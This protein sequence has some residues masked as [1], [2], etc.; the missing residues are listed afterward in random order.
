MH[1]MTCINIR[2]RIASLRIVLGGFDLK[3]QGQKLETLICQKQWELAQNA[4]CDLYR[5]WYLP[6]NASCDWCTPRIW[7]KF[8]RST[9]LNVNISE[10]REPARPAYECV[11][12]LL[13]RLIFAAKWH[14]YEGC[15]RWPWLTFS[16]SI[17]WKV[18]ISR[19]SVK[20]RL[21]RWQR[22]VFA[23]ERHLC[24]CCTSQP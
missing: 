10:R 6:S 7:P 1:A 20:M 12:W 8:S 22:F 18:N 4:D 5:R 13:Y 2:H 16:R 23:A 21:R 24:K 17:I 3:F 14:H 15:S 9:F 11:L 19:D